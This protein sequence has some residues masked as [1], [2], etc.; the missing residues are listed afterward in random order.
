LSPTSPGLWAGR[1]VARGYARAVSDQ[2]ES[3]AAATPQP[4]AGEPSGSPGTTEDG[5]HSSALQAAQRAFEAGDFAQVRVLT[6]SLVS[7]QDPE[8]ARA[9][10]ALRRRTSIDPVQ[11]GVLVFCFLL[12]AYVV[13]TYVLS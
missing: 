12:F 5:T 11:V 2:P 1:E 7:H 10:L 6:R 4:V 8:V 13:W 9:A 3:G